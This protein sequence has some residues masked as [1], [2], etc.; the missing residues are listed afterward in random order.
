VARLPVSIPRKHASLGIT[1]IVLNPGAGDG[2]VDPFDDCT[3]PNN[4]NYAKYGV[5]L[6]GKHF[7]RAR[8]GG[9]TRAIT[10][11]LNIGG[12]LT[13]VSVGIRTDTNKALNDGGVFRSEVALHVALDGDTLMS[14]NSISAAV[15]KIRSML[16]SGKGRFNETVFGEVARGSL[17]LVIHSNNH[18]SLSVT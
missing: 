16:E 1:E 13:G 3:N 18:V 10:P 7:A 4:V 11:P 9:V 5:Q 17:P 6:E 14:Q 2:A 8:L 15:Q 12:L